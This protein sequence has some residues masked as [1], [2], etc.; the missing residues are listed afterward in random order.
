MSQ[1]L[2]A[3]ALRVAGSALRRAN[4]AERALDE[5]RAARRKKTPEAKTDGPRRVSSILH[6]DNIDSIIDGSAV[7]EPPAET[8]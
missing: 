2:A 1:E 4:A 6:P 3:T 8:E 5:L 7:Y